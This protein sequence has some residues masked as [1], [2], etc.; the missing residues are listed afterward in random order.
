MFICVKP[1]Y[2]TTWGVEYKHCSNKEFDLLY[3]QTDGLDILA[4]EWSLKIFV[5]SIV[6]NFTWF[7]SGKDLLTWY[8]TETL[9]YLYLTSGFSE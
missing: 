1:L 9:K 6:F 3:L 8:F 5:P 4:V 7:I 2:V